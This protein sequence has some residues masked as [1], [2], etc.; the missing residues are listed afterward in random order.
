MC[1][2]KISSWGILLCYSISWFYY[3]DAKGE[4]IVKSQKKKKRQALVSIAGNLS[5]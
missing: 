5:G 3:V 1:C 2:G 4:F